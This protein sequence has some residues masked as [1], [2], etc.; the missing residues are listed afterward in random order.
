MTLSVVIATHNRKD[1]LART[2]PSL[3]AQDLPP[4]EYEIVLVVDG[5]TD[6]TAD[7]LRALSPRCALRIL[8][9][10]RRGPGAARNAGVAAA[11]G[12]TVL[13]LDDDITCPRL[14]V[15]NDG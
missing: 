6:G 9:A 7:M 11:R 15:S 4:A 12:D 8:E 10:P 1:V 3:L 13:F 5:S 2:L 14:L